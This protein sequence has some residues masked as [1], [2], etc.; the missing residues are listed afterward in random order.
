MDGEIIV[1][2]YGISKINIITITII[3]A[4]IISI[5]NVLVM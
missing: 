1:Q 2:L 4:D 5:F 3:F